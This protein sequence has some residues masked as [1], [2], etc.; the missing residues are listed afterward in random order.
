MFTAE[1][2]KVTPEQVRKV[3]P[4]GNIIPAYRSYEVVI[5]V[6]DGHSQGCI[7]VKGGEHHPYY[8]PMQEAF[9]AVQT[10]HQA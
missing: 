1:F 5:T 10:L 9:Q 6:E 3:I 2:H 4:V 8:L 7:V